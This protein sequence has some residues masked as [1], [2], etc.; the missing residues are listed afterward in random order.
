MNTHLIVRVIESILDHAPEALDAIEGVIQKRKARRIEDV[1][2]GTSYV[3]A[4][5]EKLRT[6]D[7]KAE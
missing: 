3:D 6:E 7:A 4:A 1:R 2:P 5:M